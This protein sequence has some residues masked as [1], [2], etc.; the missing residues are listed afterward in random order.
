MPVLAEEKGHHNPWV[1]LRRFLTQEE[2]GSQRLPFQI[3]GFIKADGEV[4]LVGFTLHRKPVAVRQ[5]L[6][7]QARKTVKTQVLGFRSQPDFALELG[8]LI[9]VKFVFFCHFPLTNRD[10]RAL[11]VGP[12]A[13]RLP[14]DIFK[15]NFLLPVPYIVLV[16]P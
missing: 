15:L 7:I 10:H 13:Q 1:D 12:F 4:I 16:E 8:P 5:A 14:H 3:F 6:C 11:V 9:N 2:A